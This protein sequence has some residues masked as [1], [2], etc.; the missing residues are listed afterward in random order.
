MKTR[1]V[2]TG[3]SE[4]SAWQPAPGTTWVQTRS[5]MHARRLAKRADGR[6]VVRGVVGG[7]LRTYEFRRR[8]SWAERLIS[9]YTGATKAANARIDP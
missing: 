3:I 5:P 7:Y 1:N 8:L 4:L 9:R 2:V 6:L